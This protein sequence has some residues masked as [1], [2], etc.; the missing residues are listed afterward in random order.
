MSRGQRWGGREF[1]DGGVNLAYWKMDDRSS[2]K[3]GIWTTQSEALY[4]LLSDV[5][6]LEIGGNIKYMYTDIHA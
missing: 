4:P 5:A 6:K 1:V 2:A 3:S